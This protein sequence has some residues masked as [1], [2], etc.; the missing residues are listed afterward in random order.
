MSEP[1]LRRRERQLARREQVLRAREAELSSPGPSLDRFDALL[2][3]LATQ[4]A[5]DRLRRPLAALVG[6]LGLWLLASPVV[7]GLSTAAGTWSCV[8]CGAALAVAAGAR[9]AG[10]AHPLPSLTIAVVSVLLIACAL[11]LDTARE[12][13]DCAVVGALGLACALAPPWIARARPRRAGAR[14]R[15]VAAL[16]DR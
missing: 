12:V 7:L 4:P 8:V 1:E 14:R 5:P 16:P 9:L 10:S 3:E 11:S 13:V 15:T 6:V 2:C